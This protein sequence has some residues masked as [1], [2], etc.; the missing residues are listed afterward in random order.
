MAWIKTDKRTNH[1]HLQ[2]RFKRP[3]GS[4]GIKSLKLGNVSKTEARIVLNRF[5]QD[6]TYLKLDLPLP[7]SE[8]TLKELCQEY[9]ESIKGLKN[10]Y[11]IDREAQML[12]SFCNQS[13]DPNKNSEA[14][15]FF[16]DISD[17]KIKTVGD[18]KIHMLDP[19][20]VEK[21]I[22][23]K[24]YKA[25]T[26]R[27]L[28]INLRAIYKY[29]VNRKYLP[30]NPMLEVRTPKLE[31]LPPR[32]VD[33]LIVEQVIKSMSGHVRDY[34]LILKYTG[35]RPSEALR[36][37]VLDINSQ[38]ITIRYSKTKRFRVIPIHDHLK[39][40]LKRLCKGKSKNEYLFPSST[41]TGHQ[42]SMKK[43]LELALKR[44][45]VDENI[46]PYSFRHTFATEL[47]RKTSN[48]RVV[49]TVLGHSTSTQTERYAHALPDSL[50]T[51][52]NSLD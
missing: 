16:K 18:L 25:N 50:I 8:I 42:K 20:A 36:L 48:L 15:I 19:Q 34:F 45:G 49:Q 11:T 27:I 43:G 52:V 23:L 31:K 33:P 38:S 32:Y 51:A 40:V 41:G 6:S 13:K 4:W 47:L 9:L 39:T 28:I 46:T 2:Y 44:S 3:D 22:Y 37:Q 5:Q 30:S 35:M 12:T 21:F 17:Q 29:A 7:S 24:K 14:Q 10:P 1:K 26:A